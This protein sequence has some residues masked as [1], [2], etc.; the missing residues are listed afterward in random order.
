MADNA[1]PG[2]L[3]NAEL[4]DL[5]LGPGMGKADPAISVKS[6]IPSP[7]ESVTQ[8]S[9]LY[10]P[11]IVEFQDLIETDSNIYMLF[12][13]MFEEIPTKPPY[14]KDPSGH[15]QVRDY[16]SMLDV[17]NEIIHRAPPFCDSSMVGFQ[18]NSIFAWI[19]GTPS[20]IVAFTND[21]V[22][23]KCCS[24]HVHRLMF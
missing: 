1:P 6:T 14:D 17:L 9:C 7:I 10:H 8:K 20:G 4:V 22:S 11:V 18:I 3:L 21:K 15:H 5:E 2:L 23:P 16:K 24:L 12:T 13:K 19:M